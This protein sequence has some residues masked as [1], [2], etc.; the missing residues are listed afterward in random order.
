[1]KTDIK[2]IHIHITSIFIDQW[3]LLPWHSSHS[4]I[5]VSA[6]DRFVPH[7][8]SAPFTQNRLKLISDYFILE[9]KW[10]LFY[11]Q[12]YF[13]C[14][15]FASIYTS[16][17][18]INSPYINVCV[19]VSVA[20]IGTAWINSIGNA[21]SFWSDF[22]AVQEYATESVWWLY[23]E[24]FNGVPIK[25]YRRFEAIECAWNCVIRLSRYDE[26]E[27]WGRRYG[28]I[29]MV[30]GIFRFISFS[31]SFFFLLFSLSLMRKRTPPH[32]Q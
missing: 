30:A 10:H 13:C 6:N 31:F 4:P 9:N 22:W 12:F 29:Q 21:E 3:V 32:T 25:F 28:K 23:N 19:C 11:V 26:S 24:F 2:Y 16:I 18:T 27:S 14:K 1:M 17:N 8:L 7:T 20:Y 15:Q 5:F